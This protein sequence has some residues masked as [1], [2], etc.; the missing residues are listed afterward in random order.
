MP[1][2]LKE[3]EVEKIGMLKDKVERQGACGSGRR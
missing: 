2:R 1:L 3:L